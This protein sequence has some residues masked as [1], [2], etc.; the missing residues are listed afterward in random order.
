MSIYSELELNEMGF[1]HIGTNCLISKKVSFYGIER[2]SLGN[3]VR[4]DDFCVLSAG[5]GGIHIGNYIHIA[6]YS[7][8]I[9][10]GKVTLLDYCNI[11]SRVSIYS[12]NDDYSG[13]YMT[14]PMID[15]EFTNVQHAP[16]TLGKHVVIGSASII[17]PGVNIEEGCAVGAF[18]LVNDSLQSWGVYVGQPAKFLKKRK[19]DLL[20]QEQKFIA[21]V[22]GKL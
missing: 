21:N 10:A 1:F 13:E 20:E 5:T 2:I 18:S 8:I 15:E 4:I 19:Q 16:V 17:L 6:V 3:N 12:S 9:G 22:E 11:S 14:N 7:C